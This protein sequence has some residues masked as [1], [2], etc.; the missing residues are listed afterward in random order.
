MFSVDSGHGD[1]ARL[2]LNS[3]ANPDHIN[4]NGQTSADI[5]ATANRVVLQ[6]VIES[7]SMEKGRSCSHVTRKDG[8][9]DHLSEM[10]AVLKNATLGHLITAFH[11]HNIDLESFLV[12]RE[13]DINVIVSGVIGDGKK[14][15]SLQVINCI[16]NELTR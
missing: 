7:F 1:I 9:Y 3:G 2:L 11:D 15:L 6:E 13:S 4:N 5:A 12:L 16:C 14:L 8:N 10:E